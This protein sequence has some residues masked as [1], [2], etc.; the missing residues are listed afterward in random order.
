MEPQ[1]VFE[2]TKNNVVFIYAKMVGELK[3]LG[4][5]EGEALLMMR[6]SEGGAKVS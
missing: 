4:P 2:D 1:S 3:G 6:M 5:W